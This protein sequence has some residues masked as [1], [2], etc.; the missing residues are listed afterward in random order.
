[1]DI[2]L[3]TID[4]ATM[5]LEFSG[6]HNPVY[7]IRDNELIELESDP[8]SIGAYVNGEREYTNHSFQLQKNDCL[9]LFSDG[10]MD[11]FGG[12]KGKKFMRK[13]FRTTLIQMHTLRMPEQKW[14]LAETL[15]KW[16][17]DNEQVDDVL[18]IGVRI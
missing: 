11:Q 10:Y 6:A 16:Q 7:I 4:P 17:G 13:Q 8:F 18:V 14:R 5:M 9:Y 3:C 12:P 15:E 1:M 2:A